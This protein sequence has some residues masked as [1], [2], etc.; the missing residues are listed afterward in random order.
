MLLKPGYPWIV[1]SMIFFCEVS[2]QFFCLLIKKTGKSMF[3][4]CWLDKIFS[5]LTAI[6]ILSGWNRFIHEQQLFCCIHSELQTVQNCTPRLVSCKPRYARATPILR[7]LHWLPVESRIIFK[8]LL[9]VYK[10]LNNLAP[11]FINSLLK[12]YKP[13]H[14]LRS[15][16]QG[17]LTIPRSNQKTYGDRSFSVAA[18][19]L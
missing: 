1:L 3:C 9:L 14:N 2:S 15:V 6:D 8:I 7:E 18:P 16:D 11:A 10:S 5:F 19:K 17:L 12:N 13:S 4:C